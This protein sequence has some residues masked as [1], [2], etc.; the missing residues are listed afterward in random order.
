MELGIASQKWAA[1]R[2]VGFVERKP[3]ED[4]YAA[5]HLFYVVTPG[6]CLPQ[7]DG[8]AVCSGDSHCGHGGVV[9]LQKESQSVWSR[10]R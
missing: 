1:R 4:V 2:G 6:A 7:I 8:K 3:R 9:L 10:Q 5:S